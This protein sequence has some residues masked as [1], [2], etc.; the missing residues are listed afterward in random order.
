MK[1]IG[2]LT[3]GGDAPGMN[4]VIYSVVLEAAKQ[5][6]EIVGY[7]NGYQGLI[8]NQ[9]VSLLP[10]DVFPILNT[11]GTVL[12]SARDLRF[13]DEKIRKEVAERLRQAEIDGMIVIGGDG[14]YRG[15][16][17]LNRLG[18]PTV[19]IPGTIDNDIP[20]TEL[21]LG[22]TTAVGNVVDAIDKI[23]T[24]A[25]SHGHIFAVEVMG[26]EAGDI[27]LW[28]GIAMGADYTICET[29][30]FNALEINK[31][32]KDS[33]AKGK[34]YQLFILA[35][36]AISCRNFKEE[37]E[38]VSDYAIHDL[39][40]GHV[41]RGGTPAVFDRILGIEFGKKA[42]ARLSKEKQG[43]CLAIKNRKIEALD[44]NTTLKSKKELI[45]P[46]ESIGG[47]FGQ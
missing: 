13:L 45:Y 21:T 15:G 29:A 20:D 38:R 7:T 19:V 1:R 37:V 6:I 42:I 2:L 44:I 25:S 39:I 36:G 14:S 4:A 43:C 17:E 28:S 11:G 9:S 3:S 18:I 22:F 47:I 30:D 12:G 23:I 33:K 40:L 10:K 46:I 5:G 27:A 41:Q 35:E 24:S 34:K 31:I 26:R 32:I 8:D 16:W